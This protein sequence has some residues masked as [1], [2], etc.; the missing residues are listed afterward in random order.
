M[1]E[2]ARSWAERLGK[3]VRA[4]VSDKQGAFVNTIA[5]VFPGIPHRYCKNHFMRDLAKPVLYADSSAKVELRRKVRGL[6]TVERQILT[7]ESSE[8]KKK[9]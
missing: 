2:E 5:E 7:E 4:W 8:Q 3:P 1:I 9:L 6:R